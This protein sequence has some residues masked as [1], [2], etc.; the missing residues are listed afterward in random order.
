MKG[1]LIF[2]LLIGVIMVII[3]IVRK[4]CPEQKIL[5]RY[6]PRSFSE[7]QTEPANVSDIFYSMFNLQDPWFTSAIYVDNR[8]QE[9][10][11]KYFVSQ[12]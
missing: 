12:I 5:Y 7:E 4:K 1:F 2:M 9:E 6:I 3:E 11:N 10:I 8:K